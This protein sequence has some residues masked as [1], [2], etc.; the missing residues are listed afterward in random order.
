MNRFVVNRSLLQLSSALS[1]STT[2]RY[3]SS[4]GAGTNV[5]I[6][7]ET[8]KS[9]ASTANSATYDHSK[10]LTRYERWL[11][12]Q[13]VDLSKVDVTK[14]NVTT[15]RGLYAKKRIISGE[16]IVSVP[17]HNLAVSGTSL[18]TYS[19]TVKRLEPPQLDSIKRAMLVRGIKDPVL[20]NL[21]QLALC[22]AA[23]RS[24]PDSFFSPYFDVLPHPAI[25]DASV[26]AMYKS[27][28]DAPDILEWGEQRKE[29]GIVCKKLCDTWAKDKCPPPVLVDWAWRTVLARQHMLP[30]RGLTPQSVGSSTLNYNAYNTYNTLETM[31]WKGKA[32]S[33]V[34]KFTGLL[35]E[36]LQLFPAGSEADADQYRLMPT[37]M[38]IL[39][40]VGHLPQSNCAVEVTPRDANGSCAELQAIRDIQPGEQIGLSFSRAH[41]AAFTLYRFGFLPV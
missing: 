16:I 17:M 39:D 22:V 30:D 11:L 38:P 8:Q 18:I 41:S 20:Y 34:R 21:M 12:D 35:P 13:R 28:L 5:P 36:S 2:F 33:L 9:T 40:Q 1:L 26:M 31:S 14:M 4:A 10:L 27:V 3:C 19:P 37:L 25:S 6:T 7:P 23:E 29:F 15:G 24:N 32:K